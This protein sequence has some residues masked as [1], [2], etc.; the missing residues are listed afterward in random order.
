MLYDLNEQPNAEKL[1]N[2]IKENYTEAEYKKIAENLLENYLSEDEVRDFI[3]NEGYEECLIKEYTINIEF[4]G[5]TIYHVNATSQE[6]AEEIAMEMFDGE[7][8]STI[9]DAIDDIHTI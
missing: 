1:L 9:I 6:E 3:E 7:N 5:N 4:I 8:Y 2:Y